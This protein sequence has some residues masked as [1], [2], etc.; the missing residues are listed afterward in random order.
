LRKRKFEEENKG[1]MLG[2]KGRIWG[3]MWRRKGE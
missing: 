3:K 2:R 1:K